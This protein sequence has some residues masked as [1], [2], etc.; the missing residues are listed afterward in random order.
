MWVWCVMSVTSESHFALIYA[1]EKPTNKNMFWVRSA[2]IPVPVISECIKYFDANDF[3]A[4]RNFREYSLLGRKSYDSLKNTEF[5]MQLLFATI[6]R[7]QWATFVIYYG[8][9]MIKLNVD[10]FREIRGFSG[11]RVWTCYKIATP[12]IE[13]VKRDVN[14]TCENG[15]LT[16]HASDVD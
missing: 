1:L 11:K 15:F 14:R 2:N 8:T 16:T 6:I 4:F 5:K 10:K 12:S 9:L 7:N 3:R 13:G